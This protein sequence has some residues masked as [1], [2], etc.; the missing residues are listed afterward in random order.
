EQ[1]LR[2]FH[3]P[4]SY[5][6]D[7]LRILP[8]P[9]IDPNRDRSIL[10]QEPRKLKKGFPRVSRMVQHA[11]TVNGIE[12][13]ATKGKVKKVGLDDIDVHASS[14]IRI[15]GIDGIGKVD[16]YHGRTKAGGYLHEPPSPAPHIENQLP[17]Q[18]LFLE[19]RLLQKC[20][21]GFVV[22]GDGIHLSSSMKI[23]L[24][25]EV[26]HIVIGGHEPWNTM[27]DRI[28]F[29]TLTAVER[30]SF[31]LVPDLSLNGQAQLQLT[32]G[33]HDNVH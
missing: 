15:R 7:V 11:D 18:L 2:D 25:R 26:P 5:A 24:K 28:G 10:L 4:S 3:S 33:T 29:P 6:I 23:P 8:G 22:S 14:H 16:A 17:L 13:L 20:F 32:R 1:L 31:D 19:A 30:T 9:H 27:A 21:V 12:R